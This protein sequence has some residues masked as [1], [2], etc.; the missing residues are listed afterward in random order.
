M[1]AII[2][3]IPHIISWTISYSH[4]MSLSKIQSLSISEFRILDQIC[5]SRER[6]TQN[7]PQ[8]PAHQNWND[9]KNNLWKLRLK[10][11]NFDKGRKDK[12]ISMFR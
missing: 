6:E 7:P 12:Y 1:M 2:I 3:I 8:I 10:I 11:N 4:W 5:C 9:K